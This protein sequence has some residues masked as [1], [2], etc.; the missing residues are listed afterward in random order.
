MI[1][2]ANKGL[3]KIDKSSFDLCS[4]DTDIYPGIPSSDLMMH[5]RRIPSGCDQEILI[6]GSREEIHSLQITHYNNWD[7]IDLLLYV[8]ISTK[9]IDMRKIEETDGNLIPMEYKFIPQDNHYTESDYVYNLKEAIKT[10]DTNT[11]DNIG[12]RR[13]LYNDPDIAFLLGAST[14]KFFDHVYKNMKIPSDE[15]EQYALYAT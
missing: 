11:M 5:V 13:D 1:R 6:H 10:D 2:D 15:M 9:P 3:L 12:Y 7:V 8:L 4:R 14:P